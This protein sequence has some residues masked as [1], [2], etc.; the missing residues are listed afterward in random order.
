MSDTGWVSPSGYEDNNG[1]INPG[2][3]YSSNNTYAVFDDFWYNSVEYKTFGISI[4]TGATIN[5]IEVS[6]EA[7]T[8][9]TA[10]GYRLEVQLS[11]DGGGTFSTAKS[12]TVT[13]ATDTNYT[14][15][16]SSDLWGETWTDSSFGSNFRIKPEIQATI[17]DGYYINVDHIQIKVYYT[18]SGP[19]VG[20]KYPLPPFKR[21]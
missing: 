11:K 1:V 6:V 3:A 16:G 5:G 7:N 2:N 8:T 19:T 20:V 12:A 15:G 21:P 9:M 4:P 18:E 10:G 14:Y 17:G 13:G